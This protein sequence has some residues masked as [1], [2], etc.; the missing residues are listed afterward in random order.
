MIEVKQLN[1]TYD[2][3]RLT[4]NHVLKDVSFTLRD[5]GFVCILGPSGCGKTSLLNAIG[6][7]DAFDSGTLATENVSVSRYGTAAYEAERNANFGYIFQNYYLLDTHSVGY[8]VYLGLHSLQ[9]S[10]KEKLRRVRQALEAVDMLRFIR[11]K[12]ADLSGGQQQRVAIARALA[13]KPRVIFADEPTGNLDEA[14]TRNI[15]TLLRQASRDSLVLMVTHEEHIARFFADRIITLEEG[16]LVGDDGE[17]DREHLSLNSDKELYTGDFTQQTLELP[18]M[19]VRLLYEEGAAPAQLT[20]IAMKDRIVLK[21][22][23]PRAAALSQGNE[24]P[25]LI[26][27][28][29]PVMSLENLTREEDSF[30]LFREPPARQAPA[31]KGVTLSM[32]AKEARSLMQGKGIRKA[33]MRI[34]LVLLTV[35]VMITTGDFIA[36]SRIAPEEY[37]S[38]DS[39]VLTITAI[40]D[41]QYPGGA[42]DKAIKLLEREYFFTLMAK[43]PDCRPLGQMAYLPTYTAR[44]FYQMEDISLRVPNHSTVPVDTLDES[45]LIY[46]RM[47]Q[48]SGEVVVDKLVL[49]SS[50]KEDGIVQNVVTDVSL[51]LDQKL[52]YGKNA[53]SPTIVGICDS[54][55][56]SAYMTP[57]AMLA[58]S[59]RGIRAIG[60]SEFQSLH[61]GEY[62]DVTLNDQECI[63]ILDNAGIIYKSRIGTYFALNSYHNVQIKDAV[64]STE[65][66]AYY[67]VSDE[68]IDE[69]LFETTSSELTLY[70]P[71][72]AAVKRIVAQG[73]QWEEAKQLKITV[74]D[75]YQREY[76][77][78]LSDTLLR[79]DARVI[80]TVTVAVIC[81]VM[82]YLLCRS[83]IQDRL[84]LVAVYRLLGIPGGKLY[85]IFLMEGTLVALGSVLPAGVLTWGVIAA[86]QRFTQLQLGMELSWQAASIVC[87]AI[88]VYYLIVSLLPLGKLLRMPPAR[89]AAQYDV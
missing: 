74:T 17:W 83:Q 25:R 27:G 65:T 24:A 67:V 7:L 87:G 41:S 21:L 13:R 6:G 58:L 86:V 30:P 5:K 79:T 40:Q 77:A 15:C 60:L 53:L 88:L 52:E 32:M 26:E 56:R 57:A 14:N 63:A 51:F 31:G 50:L 72:R 48:H 38:C 44:L 78:Y 62:D 2:R 1:K 47:P 11:R 71:D 54:G 70:C 29:R 81:L 85:A 36:V 42:E 10:H 23:D 82:L 34:F 39:H 76:D 49:E 4:A 19:N 55:E 59:L 64:N 75:T 8:N 35:L 33:G 28:D 22:A 84:S 89:L 9:L 37:V 45:T 3:R 46:G 43:L 20:V 66:H 68:L 61:P 80:V 18:Q 69:L 16:R 12:V 73:S